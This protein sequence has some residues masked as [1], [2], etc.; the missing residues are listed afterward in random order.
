[1][2]DGSFI[3]TWQAWRQPQR[4]GGGQPVLTALRNITCIIVIISLLLKSDINNDGDYDI[5]DS[6][7]ND[8]DADD[9]GCS[10]HNNDDDNDYDDADVDGPLLELLKKNLKHPPSQFVAEDGYH[11]CVVSSRYIN[12][13]SSS[14]LSLQLSFTPPSQSSSP[15]PSRLKQM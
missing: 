3:I 14:F 10:G 9:E 6:R 4:Y 5:D 15:P 13:S 8:D 1:M 7:N 2:I 11:A 12:I